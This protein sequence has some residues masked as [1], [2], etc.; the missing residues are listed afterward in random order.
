M[1]KGQMRTR[2]RGTWDARDLMRT[3]K[4]QEE[5]SL[6]TPKKRGYEYA[7]LSSNCP[8]SPIVQTTCFF[9]GSVVHVS[10]CCLLVR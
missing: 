1:R 3:W 4:M 10:V 6:P 2:T 7:L 5:R 8:Q 9:D